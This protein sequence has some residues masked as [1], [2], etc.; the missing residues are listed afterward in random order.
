M[1]GIMSRIYS[2]PSSPSQMDSLG[3][4]RQSK[5]WSRQEQDY[6]MAALQLQNKE[7]INWAEVAKGLSGRTGEN[8]HGLSL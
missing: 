4:K 3:S 1:Q 2:A 7:R 6:L 5:K 8:K